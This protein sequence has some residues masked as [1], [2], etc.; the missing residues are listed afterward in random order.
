V[1]RPHQR[2]L[3]PERTHQTKTGDADKD[4]AEPD[5][6]GVTLASDVAPKPVKSSGR[7]VVV[8]RSTTPIQLRPRPDFQ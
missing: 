3:V 1:H 8:V 5:G 7:L 6:E 2:C 4:Q